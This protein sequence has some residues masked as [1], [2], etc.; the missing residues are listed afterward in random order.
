MARRVQQSGRTGWYYRV[1]EKGR[2][3]RGD[4]IE[5]VERPAEGWTLQRILRLL[6]RDTLDIEGLAQLA[7]LEPLAESWRKIAC[8]RLESHIVE[9]WSGELNTPSD[10]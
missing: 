2:V 9:D 5:L 3:A 10:A 6:Y 4:T 7:A 8:R 1:L